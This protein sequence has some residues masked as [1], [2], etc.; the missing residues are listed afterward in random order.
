MCENKSEKWLN[1]VIKLHEGKY[2]YSKV[3][4]INLSTKVCIICPMHGEFWQTPKDHLRGR[5]CNKCGRLSGV[6]NRTKTQDGFLEEAFKVHSDIYDLSK[7]NYVD[8]KSKVVI[9]CRKHGEFTINPTKFL[10][11][12]GCRECGIEKASL[13]RTK[14]VNTFLS[15]CLNS[16]Q[17]NTKYDYSK[18]KYVND[19]TPITIICTEIDVN[20]EIHGEFQQ[21]PNN[22]I[23]KSQGCPKCGIKKSIGTRTYTFEQWLGKAKQIHGNKY[24]YFKDEYTNSNIKTPIQ[25]NNH[26][27]FWQKPSNH[28]MGQGCKK[29]FRDKS[30]I[31]REIFNFISSLSINLLENDRFILDG[32]EIDIYAPEQKIG[33]E[34]NGLIW[35]SEKFNNNKKSHLEKTEICENKGIKLIHIFED[36]WLYKRNIVESRLKNIFNKNTLKIFA[37]K[38]EIKLVESKEAKIFLDKN[39]IQGN[40]SSKI[41]VGLFYCGSLVSLMTFGECRKALGSKSKESQY[42]MLRFCNELNTTVIGGASKLLKY[43]INNYNPNEIISYADRRWSQ[44]SLYEK[45]NFQFSHNTQPNYFYVVGKKREN[46]FKYRKDILVSQGYDA[47]KSEHQIMI[48]R[49]IPRIYDCGSK[50]YTL[51]FNN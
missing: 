27:V 2:D 25:C 51:K 26:G 3:N 48:D 30:N 11:G 45:L 18:T 7:T 10:N 23:S 29:C 20:G 44:G 49:K 37:R 35:H 4:F 43:F 24:V 16:H 50:K 9:N 42:E 38:C 28:L 32:K 34:I 8:G 15:E 46:R 40:V 41:N 22:H 36:E 39:H 19:K 12:Q 5:G 14:S 13:K 47:N 17:E 21:T 6:K 33:V 31:E 1:E